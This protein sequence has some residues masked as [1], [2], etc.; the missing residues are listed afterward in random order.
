[1]AVRLD[2]LLNLSS[3]QI[4]ARCDQRKHRRRQLHNFTSN[5]N[6]IHSGRSDRVA[7]QVGGADDARDVGLA[8]SGMRRVHRAPVNRATERSAMT[9]AGA[10]GKGE[11]PA[12][13]ASRGVWR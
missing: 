12:G 9:S 1:M 6:V 4:K 7:S 11:Q 3:D 8:V 10:T 5:A 13:V 2:V